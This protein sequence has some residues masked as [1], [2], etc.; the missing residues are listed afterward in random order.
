M[1]IIHLNDFSDEER[2]SIRTLIHKNVISYM[3]TLLQQCQLFGF[4]LQPCNQQHEQ[5]IR[6]F[7]IEDR[8]WTYAML[9]KVDIDPQVFEALKA[10]WQDPAIS[11]ETMGRY[12]EFQ[13]TDSAP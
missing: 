8:P 1:K 9:T 12:R 5:T 2:Q 10:L 3:Q 6:N 11:Q 7:S 13:L 4:Q